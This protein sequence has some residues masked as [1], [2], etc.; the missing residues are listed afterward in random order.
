MINNAHRRVQNFQEIRWIGFPE[1]EITK[2]IS[3]MRSL[4]NQLDFILATSVNQKK[5]AVAVVV[6]FVF[7]VIRLG[8][9]IV[10]RI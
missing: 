2:F 3:F 1:T 10:N 7:Q 6:K 4:S 9:E 8:A 5:Y